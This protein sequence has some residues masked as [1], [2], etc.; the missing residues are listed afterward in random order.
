MD[1]GKFKSMK[2]TISVE[3]EVYAEPNYT[4][5]A[6]PLTKDEIEH[7]TVLA[8]SENIENLRGKVLEHKDD[9]LVQ[10]KI[11]SVRASKS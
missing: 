8:I 10:V 4:R 9:D 5:I 2:I 6:V 11:T 1:P 3:V 7:F